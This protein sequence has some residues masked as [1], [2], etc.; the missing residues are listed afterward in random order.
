MLTVFWDSYGVLLAH[1]Q[2]PDE[3]VNS[4]F[5]YEAMLKL[6][7]S[8]GRKHTN[9]LEEGYCNMTMPNLIQPKQLKEK[10]QEL[11]PCLLASQPE[12]VP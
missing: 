5:Y 12:L 4:P 1:F 3:N 10:I 2:K 7:E 11:M 9:Q 8:I 6:R